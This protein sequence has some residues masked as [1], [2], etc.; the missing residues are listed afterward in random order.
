MV[1]PAGRRA[2]LVEF[3]S[4][5]S[6]KTELVLAALESSAR[7]RAHRRLAVGAGRG[8][9]PARAALP[10]PRDHAGQCQ[11]LRGAAAAGARPAPYQA[12]LLSGLHDRQLR[13]A[14]RRPPAR[15]F[16]PRAR[17]RLAAD[18]RRRPRQGPAAPGG[19][20]RRRQGRHGPLQSQPAG[21]HQSRAR[22][23]LRS[24]RASSTAP[25]T[26][27][28]SSASRCISS[29]VP[30]RRCGCSAGHSSSRPGRASTP[31]TPTSIRS[32]SS[33][34]SHAAPAGSPRARGRTPTG[35]SACTS[36]CCRTAT[37]SRSD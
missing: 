15:A 35:T 31:R 23:R 37:G 30:A 8:P 14:G 18:R 26:T 27:G 22:R 36:S 1:R 9:G 24:S 19:R 21:A 13:S 29:A 34:R 25:S 11:L 16:R 33:A 28:N 5:S 3:G 7:L 6:R 20:L 10:R 32:S 12:R 2:V 4:G 17:P